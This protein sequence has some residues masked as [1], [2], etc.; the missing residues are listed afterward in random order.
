ML[1]AVAVDGPLPA[2]HWVGD[3]G[4]WRGEH[5]LRMLEDLRATPDTA[6]RPPVVVL[7]NARIQ[8]ARV[9]QA[10]LPDLAACG[11]SLSELPPASPKL[12]ASERVFRTSKHHR[13]PERR[14]PTSDALH[15]AVD[16]AFTEHAQHLFTKH[17]H[18]L[19]LAA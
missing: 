13:L 15:A 1:A 2:R 19:G 14:S 4:M 11:V 3:A 17:A 10:A 7:D 18:H 9:V 16:R 8:H 12:T 5:R 6:G